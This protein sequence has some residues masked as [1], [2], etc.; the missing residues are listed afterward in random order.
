MAAAKPPRVAPKPPPLTFQTA[1]LQKSAP[2]GL[3]AAGAD[4]NLGAK[5]D[6]FSPGHQKTLMQDLGAAAQAAAKDDANPAW[7]AGR[8]VS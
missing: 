8:H 3:A 4:L 2:D 7:A 1:S 6:T 5:L